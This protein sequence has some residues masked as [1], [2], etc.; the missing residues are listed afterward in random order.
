M[1][2]SRTENGRMTDFAIVGTGPC[3]FGA[4]SAS[5]R[6]DMGFRLLGDPESSVVTLAT[7]GGPS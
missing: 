1:N 3:W 6:I 5:G 2:Y 4:A 7:P